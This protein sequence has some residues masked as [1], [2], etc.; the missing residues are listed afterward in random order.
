MLIITHSMWIRI[1]SKRIRTNFIRIRTL[2][3]L[4]HT[5]WG[6]RTPNGMRTINDVEDTFYGD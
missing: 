5:L 4:G 1:H 6:L 3:G 2:W